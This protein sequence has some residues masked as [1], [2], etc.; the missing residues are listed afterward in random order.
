MNYGGKPVSLVDLFSLLLQYSEEK[1]V[2][3]EEDDRRSLDLLRSKLQQWRTLEEGKLEGE[4]GPGYQE[5]CADCVLTYVRTSTL[6]MV[7]SSFH[8]GF[9]YYTRIYIC[10]ER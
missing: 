7:I 8:H 2:E 5:E 10:T 1:G 6:A 9:L 3:E 4:H